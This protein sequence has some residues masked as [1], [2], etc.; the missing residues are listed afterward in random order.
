MILYF[1]GTGN[2]RHV[3][4]RIAEATGDE[5]EDMA[6]HL[7][8]GESGSY[9]SQQ[10]Y[11]FVGPVYAGRYPRV[12]TDFI[13]KSRFAGSKQAYFVATCAETPWVTVRY[14]KK[15]ADKKG[16]DVMGFRSVVM[17]QGY[18]TG[19]LTKPKEEN[20]AVLAKAEPKIEE[21]ADLIKEGK[22]LP[23]E[24][25]GK[26][27][28]STIVNPMMYATMMSA[29]KFTAGDSCIGCGTCVAKCPLGNIKLVDGRPAWGSN[30]T[31]CCA[32]ISSC[33]QQA[34]EYGDKTV[35]KP[36]YYLEK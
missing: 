13:Q 9:S 26:S 15:L 11:V 7:R 10:P 3:A 14:A 36:R 6:L 5:A 31:Q 19:G 25:P 29:K 33:P 2:S 8:K 22:R 32:C 27:Y 1:T 18:C 17:P 23:D 35:G 16:F 34:I 4:N 24:A 12:M 28:M 30:C 20:D 21:L